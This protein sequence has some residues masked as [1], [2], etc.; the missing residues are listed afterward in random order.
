MVAVWRVTVPMRRAKW[1]REGRTLV[2]ELGLGFEGVGE[3]EGFEVWFELGAI[4]GVPKEE[5]PV[6]QR[7]RWSNSAIVRTFKFSIDE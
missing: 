2:V 7:P 4:E 5:A 6:R 3:M 1:W